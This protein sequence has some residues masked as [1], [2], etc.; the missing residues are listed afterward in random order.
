M[1]NPLPLV[2][3]VVLAVSLWVGAC[4][5]GARV[6]GWSALAEAYRVPEPFRGPSWTLPFVGRWWGGY[7]YCVRAGAN[8]KGLALSVMI[9][10]GHPP[11]F[12][13]WDEIAVERVKRWFLFITV[14]C[15]FRRAPTVCLDLYFSR[16]LRRRLAETAGR[17]WPGFNLVPA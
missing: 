11:L 15:R 3:F 8:A 9:F 17:A 10:P 1:E 6:S 2:A 14:R 16:R 7:T 12:I 13:P 4:F 5:L